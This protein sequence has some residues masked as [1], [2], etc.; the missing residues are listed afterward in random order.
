M[1]QDGKDQFCKQRNHLCH[2]S[3]ANTDVSGA[4][5]TTIASVAS[6]TNQRTEQ[7]H[8]AHELHAAA[9]AELEQSLPPG[10][11]V[12]TFEGC[13]AH[14]GFCKPASDLY[15]PLHVNARTINLT[16]NA[17]CF[18]HQGASGTPGALL[19]LCRPSPSQARTLVIPEGMTPRSGVG[20]TLK[21]GTKYYPFLVLD[22]E[23]PVVLSGIYDAVM[24][25]EGLYIL[26]TGQNID[27]S[28]LRLMSYDELSTPT[29]SLYQKC[30]EFFL[31]RNTWLPTMGFVA[32][33]VHGTI[34]DAVVEGVRLADAGAGIPKGCR[35]YQVNLQKRSLQRQTSP[36][37]EQDLDALW[38]YHPDKVH[39]WLIPAHVLGEKGILA[40]PQQPG[41]SFF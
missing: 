19:W 36:M 14:L 1:L 33:D 22:K 21:E 38:V 3:T 9:V 28:G 2:A 18:I 26:P 27:I 31:L 8:Y 24:K 25:G 11:V 30:R 10:R 23:L 4:A 35:G 41:K 17:Y 37:V 29:S 15:L 34:V 13:R 32:P 7:Q 6:S 12:R 5:P 20:L 16:N 39:F 40:T